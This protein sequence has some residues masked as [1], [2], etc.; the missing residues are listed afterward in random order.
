M[1]TPACT[2]RAPF[3]QG[4]SISLTVLCSLAPLPVAHSILS[5]WDVLN[6]FH[7]SKSAHMSL[8]LGSF[9]HLVNFGLP[10][11]CSQSLLYN[12]NRYY[13]TN[14]IVFNN[15]STNTILFNG[16]VSPKGVYTIF[17]VSNITWPPSIPKRVCDR[18][19]KMFVE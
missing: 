16:L 2:P 19:E 14:N 11:W 4:S 17:L 3:V 8:V 1:A 13:S 5:L 18:L 15:Y 6:S 9:S 10:P 12:R 7:H